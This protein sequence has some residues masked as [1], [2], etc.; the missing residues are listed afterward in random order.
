MPLKVPDEPKK[1]TT[2]YDDFKGVDF[3]NDPSNVYRRRSPSG[4]NM[5]PD[6]DGRPYKR[7]G[8]EVVKTV[9]DF[10]DAASGTLSSNQARL[11]YFSYGDHEYLMIFNDLGVFWMRDTWENDAQDLHIAKLESNGTISAFP[12][13]QGLYDT[14]A[15]SNR[16]FFFEGNGIS[17]FYVFVGMKLYRFCLDPDEDSNDIPYFREV[18]PK[19]P[20]VLTG[21]DETGT[22]TVLDPINMLT[23]K[24]TVEYFGD[25]TTQDWILPPPAAASGS[26]TVEI[27]LNGVWTN[28]PSDHATY[29]WSVV[30]NVKVRFSTGQ[31]PPASTVGNMRI[32]YSAS[33]TSTYATQANVMTNTVTLTNKRITTSYRRRTVRK[34]YTETTISDRLGRGSTTRT[35]KKSEIVQTGGWQ[36]S[37]AKSDWDTDELKTPSIL[38]RNTLVVEAD[39]TGTYAAVTPTLTWGSYNNGVKIQFKRDDIANSGSQVTKDSAWAKDTAYKTV[40]S[41]TQESA[42]TSSSGKTYITCTVVETYVEKQTRT[43]TKSKSFHA[44]GKYTKYY[45]TGADS[46]L[47]RQKNAFSECSKTLNFG[48]QIYNQAFI[49]A[50]KTREYVNRVWYSAANDVSYWPDTNYIEVGAD[51]KPV[52][53]MIKVGQYLGVV[54]KGSGTEAS[55]YLAYATSFDNNTTYAVKQSVSGVGAISN[56]AFNIL[57][58]E[59]LFLSERGVMGINIGEEDKNKQVRNRSWFINGRLKKEAQADI[60]SAISFV[61]DGLY[62]LSV[63][64]NCYVLDGSQKSSWAN[65][66]TNLQYECYYLENLPV[67]CFGQM[68]DALW[69]TDNYGNLCRMKTADDGSRFVDE[70]TTNADWTAGASPV[71]GQIDVRLL[72]GNSALQWLLKG[73]VEDEYETEVY[74]NHEEDPDEATDRIIVFSGEPNIG[75]TVIVHDTIECY[76]IMEFAYE[77]TETFTGDG[78][79]TEFEVDYDIDSIT[80]ATVDG[81]TETPTFRGKVVTFGTAPGDGKEVEI[82]YQ[83]K[84]MASADDTNLTHTYAV[85]QPGVPVKAEWSTF[86]DDDGMIHFFKNLTKKG[87]V[88]SILPGNESGA[89]VYLKADNND[90]KYLGTLGIFDP[91]D[92][93]SELYPRKKMKK[94]KRLQIICRNNAYNDEFGID[95][96]IKTYTVGNYSKNRKRRTT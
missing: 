42:T 89:D 79:T 71:G 84:D 91:S 68:Q 10:E 2:I 92:L 75:D 49:A 83:T 33:T 72:T 62:Y 85:V 1:Y 23:D 58:E 94:Y 28:I 73:H 18:T 82:V 30:D 54:K 44:R 60:E 34:T 63:G 74:I 77:L 48:N 39:W 86:A 65:E 81:V 61:H 4:L 13:Q 70:Y 41:K 32:T 25:G 3:T 47:H 21:C 67:Q 8:W 35:L 88:I 20:I 26:V 90:P 36:S 38:H 40:T 11:H 17:G 29:P 78:E 96:I 80:S 51:D 57:S 14:S 50:S 56:G 95:Q 12:P 69:F 45:M 15:D 19:I 53:G 22:G 31:K 43:V 5:I 9:S 27:L 37:G 24:R 76:T 66:K 87:C 46:E 59:P 93:P 6:L 55:I 7:P 16:A 52:M 64:D